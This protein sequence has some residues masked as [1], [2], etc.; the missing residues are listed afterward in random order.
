MNKGE[1][2][3]DINQIAKEIENIKE[4]NEKNKKEEKFIKVLFSG[5]LY[6]TNQ[7]LEYDLKIGSSEYFYM[8]RY[9]LSQFYKIPVN[10][11]NIVIDDVKYNNRLKSHEEFNNIKFDMYNDLDSSYE[12][13]IDLEQ[14]INL[15]IDN[16]IVNPL[17]LKVEV[18]K[19]ND[20]FKFIKSIIKDYPKLMHLLKRKHSECLLDVWCLI[21]ED[22]LKINDD[23]IQMIKDILNNKNEENIDNIFNF[24]ETNIYYISFILFH[25][26]SVII[27]YHQL[28]EEFINDV[29]LKSKIWEKIKDINIEISNKPHLGEI[30][31][32]NN[33]INYFL[34]IFKIISFKTNDENILSFILNKSFEFYFQTI[35]DCININLK[36]LPVTE[37]FQADFVEDLYISNTNAIKI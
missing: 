26:N 5:N 30:F 14:K 27:E 2:I 34:N 29:F 7:P 17:I 22:E 4:I 32:K 21:R 25:L 12:A 9:K 19:E 28:N 15:I 20:Y 33:I 1:I 3:K 11:I 23:I 35:N 24:N 6:K 31:E 18:K 36:S 8:F 16:N 37:G 13:F 10:L